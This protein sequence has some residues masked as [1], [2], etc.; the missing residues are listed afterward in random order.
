MSVG[1]MAGQVLVK[2]VSTLSTVDS[3]HMYQ[4]Q[5]AVSTCVAIGC[6]DVLRKAEH[7]LV[8]PVEPMPDFKAD[9]GVASM[10]IVDALVVDAQLTAVGL[11]HPNS[12]IGAR[13]E[14]I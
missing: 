9:L 3:E 5:Q 7:H 11:Y 2:K 12:A 8:L 14:V 13:G 10:G 4:P 6:R 1:L